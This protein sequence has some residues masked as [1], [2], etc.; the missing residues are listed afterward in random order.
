M[1]GCGKVGGEGSPA[2]STI[3]LLTLCKWF[4]VKC[5]RLTNV[6]VEDT[7]TKMESIDSQE[8]RVKI[9]DTCDNVSRPI[10]FAITVTDL[11]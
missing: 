6:C 1:E 11:L 10:Y 5:V 8:I 3:H 7:Y 9:M 2:N 4:V